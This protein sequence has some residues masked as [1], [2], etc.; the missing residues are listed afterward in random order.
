MWRAGAILLL[1]LVLTPA[2]AQEGHGCHDGHISSDPAT[3]RPGVIVGRQARNHFYSGDDFRKDC[4][5]AGAVCRRKGFVVPGDKVLVAEEK[6][7]G[8]VCVGFVDRRGTVSAGWLP[9]QAV[10]IR[11]APEPPLANWL[12]KWGYLNSTITIKRGKAAGTLDLD[13]D[14]WSKRYQS[15]NEGSFFGEAVKPNGNLVAFAY[16]A[17]KTIPFEKA[18]KLDCAIKLALLHG[19]LVVEDNGNCGGAGVHFDGFYRRK[20]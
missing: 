4:P 16:D 6:A 3:L 5:G 12:G 8:L 18:D 13:G 1:V 9:E 15:V 19:L 14:S 20:R 2:R 11:Q 10:D 17:E 7:P